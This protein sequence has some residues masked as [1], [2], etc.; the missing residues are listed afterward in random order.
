MG[1]I[2]GRQNDERRADDR[3]LV[4]AADFT[5]NVKFIAHATIALLHYL[6]ALSEKLGVPMADLQPAHVIA[7]LKDE[8]RKQ[9][10]HQRVLAR[11]ALVT[12]L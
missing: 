6:R 2:Y 5:H 4:E 9:R 1:H 10:D 3:D 8:D 12:D 11:I 7:D